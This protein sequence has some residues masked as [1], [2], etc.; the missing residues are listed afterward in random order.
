MGPVSYRVYSRFTAYSRSLGLVL[1]LTTCA[2]GATVGL[3]VLSIDSLIPGAPGAPGVNAFTISNFTGDAASGGFALLPDFP[4]MTPLTFRGASLILNGP[5]GLQTIALGDLGPG[6]F[7]PLSLHFA[8][9][10]RFS[11]ASLSLT[12]DRQ[13]FQLGGSGTFNANTANIVTQ[14]LPASGSSLVPGSDFALIAANNAPSAIPEPA[15]SGLA[16]FGTV[17][18]IALRRAWPRHSSS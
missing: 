16:L 5:S 11:S 12:L 15:S 9:T 18:F 6:Q 10:L 8:D 7:S 17:I 14:L 2:S 1:V 3:G 13:S 4:A